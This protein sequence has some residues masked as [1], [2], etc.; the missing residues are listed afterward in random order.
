MMLART[1]LVLLHASACADARCADAQ[2]D[3][4]KRL[5]HHGVHCEIKAAGG[6]VFCKRMWT[7]LQI[8][9][10]GCPADACAVPR[11]RDIKVYQRSQAAMGGDVA[12]NDDEELPVNE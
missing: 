2:C 9:A 7:L 4:L 1:E 10:R 5:F 11:C 12:R 6:C 8:H 3:K